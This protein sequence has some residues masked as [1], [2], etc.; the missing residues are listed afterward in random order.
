MLHDL[1]APRCAALTGDALAAARLDEIQR[2]GLFAT[3]VDDAAGTLRLHDLFRDALQHRLRVERPENWLALLR[4]AAA[5]EPDLV[6]R[7]AM[8]LQAHQPEDAARGLLA[9]CGAAHAGRRPHAAAAGRAV[10]ARHSP[11]RAP[12]CS[13]G[14]HRQVGAVGN[15]GRPSGT[16]PHAE[17]LYAAR[18]DEAAQRDSRAASAPITLIALGRL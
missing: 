5:V 15:A 11:P 6:R 13:G 9:A 3:V 10:P 12:S 4:R 8:L 1:D 16:S 7:Q 18:G 2:L 14:R 17:A